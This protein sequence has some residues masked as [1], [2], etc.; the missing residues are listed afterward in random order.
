MKSHTQGAVRELLF[1]LSI[2]LKGAHAVLEILGGLALLFTKPDAILRIVAL[3]TQDELVEDPN[4]LVANYALHLAQAL[5]LRSEHFATWY[6]LSH[7]VVKLLLVS[8][9]LRAKLWAYPVSMIVFGV[10]IGYQVY[11]YTFTHFPLLVALSVFDGLVIWLIWLEYQA[12]R[13]HA[14]S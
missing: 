10:F 12:L 5:T 3:L 7:G 8:A 11:R 9:L 6:L 1:R 14:T 2:S 4:D 13:R